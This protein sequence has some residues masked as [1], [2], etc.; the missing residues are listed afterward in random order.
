M[1]KTRHVP[2]RLAGLATFLSLAGLWLG[3][4]QAAENPGAY[5]GDLPKNEKQLIE[6]LKT[7]APPEKAV[8][9]KQLTIY[10]GKDSVPELAKLLAD[11]ELNSWCRIALEAIPDP[12]ADEALRTAAGTLKGREL[13]GTL[14]SI[15]VRRDAGAVPVLTSR[16]SDPDAET[17]SAAAVALGR[18]GN[19]AATEALKKVLAGAPPAVRSA[20]AEGLILCAERALAEG[21]SPAAVEVYDLV[22]KADVPKPR[23][24]EATRGAILARNVQGIPLL[25]EQLRSSDKNLSEIALGT[26]RELPG[27]EVAEA[28]A[29]VLGELSPTQAAGLLYAL[30]DRKEKFVP[31]QALEMAKKGPTPV[32][33]AAI[34]LIGSAG[35]ASSV[36][37]L[38]EIA[39]SGDPDVA[40]AAKAAL[41]D[42]PG[43][44]VNSAILALFAKADAKTLPVL[45][46]V[47]GAR[48]LDASE[49]LIKAIALPDDAIRAAAL[50]A[51]GETIGQGQLSVLVAQVVTPRNEADG[52]VAVNAL[53]AAAIRMP[54]RDATSTLLAGAL[55]KASPATQVTLIEI[56]GSVGGGKALEAIAAAVAGGNDPLQDAGTK[57]LGEWLTADAAPVLLNL[58][59]TAPGD[60]YKVRSLRAYIRI[61]RQFKIPEPER[62]EMC[63]QA[64]AAAARP[65]EQKLVLAVLARYASLESLRQAV[66][67]AKLSGLENDAK[68]AVMQI[69]QKLGD[70][71]G[72]R[73][74]LAEVG[75]EP[76]KV[77][78]IKATYG[79]GELQKDVTLVLQPLVGIMPVINLPRSNYNMSF[80]G[81]PAPNQPKQLKISYRIN[82]K[83]AEASFPE[84]APIV[85]PMPK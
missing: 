10:G 43:E 31:Q 38:L 5:R 62:E 67:A 35:N 60:K 66:A 74:L 54:D 68:T 23:I 40:P 16:L 8:V 63:R 49:S 28:L 13:V 47:V 4:G 64:M 61:A 39:S 84:E 29:K 57:Q 55:P 27:R 56:L 48:R 19:P 51:L 32:R 82:G 81:D 41:S 26:A 18:I 77:E 21:K 25:V 3:G 76:L 79:S 52:K 50:T 65:D 1:H 12:S 22:R 80:G 69:A 78:I 83:A 75:L 59:K 42:L 85:L 44:G 46:E 33:I 70:V 71:K 72:V 53:R 17:A 14:N 6:M 20:V 37:P 30:V 11:P 9:C 36:A 34:T 58:A 15:G 45:I 7:A 24:V 73:D 2:R